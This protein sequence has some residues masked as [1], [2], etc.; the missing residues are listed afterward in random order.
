M[1]NLPR[2]QALIA[3]LSAPVPSA[4]SIAAEAY[5]YV[6]PQTNYFW[7][8]FAAVAAFIGIE[9]V[10]GAS[11]YATVKLHRQRDYGIEFWVALMGIVVY[12]VSGVGTLWGSPTIIF[13]FLAPFAYFAYSIIRSMETE[14]I[15]KT[16][17]TEAQIRLIEA[18]TRMGV[19]VKKLELAQE[20]EKTKQIKAEH[21]IPAN[22]RNLPVD[23]GQPKQPE[24]L[25]IVPTSKEEFLELYNA[26]TITI[27]P[28]MKSAE[29]AK[30]LP[31]SERTVRNWLAGIKK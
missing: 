7:G 10:G 12:I 18:Q 15:E 29:L 16:T 8:Y 14:I 13:F 23:S 30:H 1:I 22:D 25:P 24:W 20:K 3:P 21:Q 19:E 28:K 17:E 2:L 6:T 5:N 26:G 9:T 31:V 4:I 11:C 27:P